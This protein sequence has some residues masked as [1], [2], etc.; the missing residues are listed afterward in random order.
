MDPNGKVRIINMYKDDPEFQTTLEHELGHVFGLEDEYLFQKKMDATTNRSRKR[1]KEK[2]RGSSIM[3]RS[4]S[5]QCDDVD[6]LINLIDSWN[7][8]SSARAQNGWES[9]CGDGTIYKCGGDKFYDTV[10]EA[11]TT[12]KRRK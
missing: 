12:R 10:E 5:V 1:A 4:E 7:E 11:R 3:D 8:C 2:S 9:V 6:G